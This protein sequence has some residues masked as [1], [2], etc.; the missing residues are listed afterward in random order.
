M[1]ELLNLCDKN[2][3]LKNF[4][5]IQEYKNLTNFVIKESR[6]IKDEVNKYLLE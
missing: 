1:A 3:I 2:V 4:K 6:Q 5:N